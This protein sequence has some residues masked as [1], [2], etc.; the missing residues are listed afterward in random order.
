LPNNNL[1]QAAK[2]LKLVSDDEFLPAYNYL[3]YK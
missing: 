2:L 1:L 3:L